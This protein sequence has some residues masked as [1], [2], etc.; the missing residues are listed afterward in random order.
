MIFILFRLPRVGAIAVSSLAG[1]VFGVRGGFF[2][3]LFYASLTGGGMAA[4][5]YPR[6]AKKYA[7]ITY[8]FAYGK[9]PGD[10]SQKDLPKFPTSFVEVKDRVVDL[11][12]KAYDAVF[13]K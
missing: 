13:K 4:F 3:K 8:N 10:E 9:K 11:S 2:K 5:C 12:G 6:E 1:V 7:L